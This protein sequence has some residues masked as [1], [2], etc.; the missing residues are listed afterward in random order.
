MSPIPKEKCSTKV[1]KT[2]EHCPNKPTK[3]LYGDLLCD[4]CYQLWVRFK[5]DQISLRN[6]VEKDDLQFGEIVRLK[7]TAI[8]RYM[9]NGKGVFISA[10]DNDRCID[11]VVGRCSNKHNLPVVTDEELQAFKLKQEAEAK[12]REEGEKNA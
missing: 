8:G 2:G 12:A 11:D 7:C 1:V 9:C 3:E 4:E 5:A 10:M 6:G